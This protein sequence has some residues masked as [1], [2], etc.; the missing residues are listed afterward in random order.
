MLAP[1][2]VALLGA[3]AP[4]GTAV[5]EDAGAKSTITGSVVYRERTALPPDAVVRVRLEVAAAPERPAKRVSEVTIPA[6][7]RQVPIPFELPYS[8]ADIQPQQRYFVRATISSGSRMLFVSRTPYAVLTKGAPSKVEILV[9]P[10]GSARNPTPVASKTTLGLTGAEWT[11]AALG[12]P[13]APTA[14]GVPAA[15]LRLDSQKGTLSGSTGCNRY[16][17]TFRLGEAGALRL[18]PSG[19]TMMACEDP[20]T[21]QETALLAALRAT[22]GFK[23]EGGVLELLGE[24]GRV[25]ARFTSGGGVKPPSN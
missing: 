21:Q 22:T 8:A 6:E 12:D 13:L 23:V 10:A 19:M 3:A 4:A 7:G 9:Q 20:A 24:G 14:P 15:T 16:M 5:A 18:E 1:I 11:L 25:V 17:G 2:V